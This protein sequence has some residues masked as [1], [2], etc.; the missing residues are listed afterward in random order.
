M[1][2]IILFVVFVSAFVI[3]LQAQKM[4]KFFDYNWR[5]CEPEMARFYTS[6]ENTDSGW[7]R[8]DYFIIENKL[9]MKGLYLDSACKIK[10][11]TFYFFHAN[12]KLQS[13][14][15]YKDDKKEGLWLS[16]HDNGFMS[17]STV[18]SNDEAIGIS[19]QWYN[20]GFPSDSTEFNKYGTGVK[21]SWFD[22]G[23]IS[24]AGR[25][26]YLQKLHGKWQYF[27]R[28]G[29]L[30]AV[31][32]YDNGRLIDRKYF[33]EDGLPMTD[34]ADKSR[35]AAFPGGMSAWLKFLERRLYFPIGYQIVNGDKAV[36]VVNFT[37]DENG[38]VKDVRLQTP[39]HPVFNDLAIKAFKNS[40]KWI[41]AMNHNRRVKYQHT[42]SVTFINQAGR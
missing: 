11:G 16:Y 23:S 30:S 25:L 8:L 3:S 24:S 42:Q 27:H 40:P 5:S 21:I 14:G 38:D 9:Q 32:V 34:T 28:N 17:D 37:I 18:Y 15:K 20:N 6:I 39:F 4:E 41:P 26:S 35:P 2:K 1:K 36:V 22:D 7:L 31:E 29:K 33:S 12:G 10:N 19:L 13:K